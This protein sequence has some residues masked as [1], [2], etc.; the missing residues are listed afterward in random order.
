MISPST[1]EAL[2]QS[3]PGNWPH[4]ECLVLDQFFANGAD[5][6]N[7]VANKGQYVA[8]S[9]GLVA[10]FSRSNVSSSSADTA[11]NPVIS[12]KW[13]EDARNQNIALAAFRRS[14]ELFQTQA[15]KPVTISE[16]F[17]GVNYTS[18]TDL[19]HIIRASISSAYNAAGTS[20]IG[21]K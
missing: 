21:R 14:R 19:L 8:A 13:L 2:N 3:F 20:Q 7:G 12:P 15:M 1:Q 4:I 6:S 11:V 16:A 9:V 17:P 18:R 5:S 10:T